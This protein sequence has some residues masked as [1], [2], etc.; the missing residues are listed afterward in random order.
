MSWYKTPEQLASEQL[1]KLAAAERSERDKRLQQARA[2]LERHRDELAI[3]TATT[4]EST[5]QDLL[6]Y[7][8]ALRDVPQQPGFPENITWPELGA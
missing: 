8:Q 3:G 2:L 7:I 5:E 6:L 4:L 1:E